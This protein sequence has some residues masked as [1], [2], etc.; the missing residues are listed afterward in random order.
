MLTAK[1]NT[2]ALIVVQFIVT[3]PSNYCPAVVIPIRLYD[4]DLIHENLSGWLLAMLA[5]PYSIEIPGSKA[6]RKMEK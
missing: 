1:P 5:L 3:L 6:A 2:S 4:C